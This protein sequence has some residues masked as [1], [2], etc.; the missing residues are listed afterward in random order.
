MSVSSPTSMLSLLK[1]TLMYLQVYLKPLK[2]DIKN[3]PK[4][5]LYL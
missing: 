3:I 2:T 1:R 5:D 4:L